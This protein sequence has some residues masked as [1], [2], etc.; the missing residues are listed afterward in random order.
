M[1]SDE[2]SMFDDVG[3]MYDLSGE[4]LARPDIVLDRLW[5]LCVG[6]A[7]QRPRKPLWLWQRQSHRRLR[8]KMNRP[9]AEQG[10]IRKLETDI[11]MDQDIV[12]YDVYVYK[13][14]L[15]RLQA[16]YEFARTR[17]TSF[18]QNSTT[19]TS[20]EIPG[21]ATTPKLAHLIYE[22]GALGI[23]VLQSRKGFSITRAR[24]ENL[25]PLDVQQTAMDFP[26]L[27]FAIHHLTL[28]YLEEC[29]H[30]AARFENVSIALSGTMRLPLIA[31]GNTRS[32][33]AGC[34]AA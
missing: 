14:G 16:Q 18:D 25:S 30:I 5:H 4:N 15:F 29:V 31:S 28:L 11:D 13:E 19:P 17:S 26:D 23:S 2:I 20:T 1:P 24:L 33:W 10:G 8:Q 32:T 21:A 6:K 12:L 3:Y 9:R 27:T 34:L 22:K 7:A